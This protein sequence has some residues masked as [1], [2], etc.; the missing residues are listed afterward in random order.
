MRLPRDM[1][2]T[3]ARMQVT[4]PAGRRPGW[5]RRAPVLRHGLA[6]GI[7]VLGAGARP[8]VVR[9]QP[10]PEILEEALVVLRIGELVAHRDPALVAN[11]GATSGQAERVLPDRPA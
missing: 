7:L 6:R 10:D 2:G 1:S 11:R 3:A 5:A 9:L 8:R 4:T